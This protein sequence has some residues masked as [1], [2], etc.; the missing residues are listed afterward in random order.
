M[1]SFKKMIS[2]NL[3]VRS[4]SFLDKAHEDE[5]TTVPSELTCPLE[6]LIAQLDECRWV[7]R[8]FSREENLAD[9]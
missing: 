5:E 9:G 4:S 2:L 1:T 7:E 3:M 8:E 6:S